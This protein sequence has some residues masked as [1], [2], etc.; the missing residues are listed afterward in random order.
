M[1]VGKQKTTSDDNMDK[2]H[3]SKMHL[4]IIRCQTDNYIYNNLRTYFKLL[5]CISLTLINLVRLMIGACGSYMWQ[6]FQNTWYF[7]SNNE[8]ILQN[9]W[10]LSTELMVVHVVT[11]VSSLKAINKLTSRCWRLQQNKII[12]CLV[13]TKSVDHM[14]I[15]VKYQKY[16][17]S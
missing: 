3:V 13:G 11:N 5:Q 17:Y 16:K 1:F 2:H 14:K 6:Q 9:D 15:N 8:F 4:W 12:C 10:K 7:T